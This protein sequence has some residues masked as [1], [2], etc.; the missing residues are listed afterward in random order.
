MF[1]KLVI[2]AIAVVVVLLLVVVGLIIILFIATAPTPDVPIAT[3]SNISQI[4]EKEVP[5]GYIIQKLESVQRMSEFE[6]E[7]RP[8]KWLV[9]TL[10]NKTISDENEMYKIA[11]PICKG[12]LRDNTKY[13]G[14]DISPHTTLRSGVNC[15]AWGP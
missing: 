9:L 7:H 6:D 14:L 8:M 12:L 15:S 1:R 5:T 3:S 13:E 4:V 11:E 10:K 2:A